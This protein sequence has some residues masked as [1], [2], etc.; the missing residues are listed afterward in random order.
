MG[1]RVVFMLTL[2]G[3]ITFPRL[4]DFCRVCLALAAGIS[5]HVIAAEALVLHAERSG[6]MDLA[7]TGRLRGQSAG[8]TRYL[9]WAELHALPTTKLKLDDEFGKGQREITAVFLAEIWER[10]PRAAGADVVLATCSDGYA[11]VFRESR[12]AELRPFLVLEID[13]RG[14]DRW[15]PPGLKFNPAPYV[16]LVSASVAPEVAKLLDPGHKKPWCLTQI[17]VTSYTERFAGVHRGRWATLSPQAT[18]GREIWINACASCHEGPGT[19]FGGTKSHRPFEF[20]EALAGYNPDLFRRYV[21]DPKSVWPEA[22]ME[23][24]P[25]YTD[26]RFEELIAFMTAGRAK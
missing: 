24:H 18:A 12:F 4:R 16:I 22:R 3:M 10:L 17:E 11:S 7:V 13:G 1:T 19:T 8:E 23:A 2:G 14:P 5:G 21:R 26:A 6:P 25:H 20:L 15:P 9:R